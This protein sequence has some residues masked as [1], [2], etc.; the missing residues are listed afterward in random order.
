MRITLAG[1]VPQNLATSLTEIKALVEGSRSRNI[2][3][4]L[5]DNADRGPI[6]PRAFLGLLDPN[7]GTF[8]T[9]Q[10]P[11]DPVNITLTHL[12]TIEFGG[13]IETDFLRLD[14]GRPEDFTAFLLKLSEKDPNALAIQFN[15]ATAHDQLRG[16]T[17]LKIDIGSSKFFLK[18]RVINF[19]LKWDLIIETN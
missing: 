8:N 12:G 17:A 18:G 4:L 14:F 16:M 10:T 2:R 15:L 9:P 19:G 3:M 5:C 1:R 6:G 7:K 13:A 11:N